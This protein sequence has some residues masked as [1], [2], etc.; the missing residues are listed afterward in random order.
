MRDLG[1]IITEEILS[2]QLDKQLEQTKTAVESKFLAE[3]P[4]MLSEV[5]EVKLKSAA[6]IPMGWAAVVLAAM[7]G[8][9]VARPLTGQVATLL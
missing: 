2:W 9:A 1:P 7:F 8:S 4:P 6:E 3:S 5:R